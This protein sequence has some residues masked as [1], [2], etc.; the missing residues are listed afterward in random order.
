MLAVRPSGAATVKSVFQGR[1]IA[2]HVTTRR[3]RF[4]RFRILLSTLQRNCPLTLLG[5]R[6]RSILHATICRLV[7]YWADRPLGYNPFICEQKNRYVA[8]GFVSLFEGAEAARLSKPN[9][10]FD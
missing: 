4:V 10:G 9:G 3:C 6:M 5:W 7:N 1:R 2:N 8:H